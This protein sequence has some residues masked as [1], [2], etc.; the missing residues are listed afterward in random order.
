M[1][2]K[3]TYILITILP[4]LLLVTCQSSKKERQAEF[5]SPNTPSIIYIKNN[6]PEVKHRIPL[7]QIAD[8][9]FY[10][11][12]NHKCP[13]DI[14][15]AWYTNNTIF[16][17]DLDSIFAFNNTGILRYSISAPVSSIDILQNEQKFYIYS[18]K[19]KTISQYDFKGAKEHM[20][21]LKSNKLGGYGSCFLTIND[22][23]FA[24]SR[25]NEGLNPYELLFF[26]KKGKMVKYI[27]NSQPFTPQSHA[28]FYNTAWERMLFRSPQGC[29]Y[30]RPYGDTLF[31][32]SPQI[33]LSPIWIEQKLSKVPLKKRLEYRGMNLT[34][35]INLCRTEQWYNIRYI[36]NSRYIIA[37]YIPGRSNYDIPNYMVYDKKTKKI[38]KTEQTLSKGIAYQNFHFGFFN[39]YDGGLGFSP[40]CQSNDYLLMINAGYA[41]GGAK[42]FP[43]T[44]Y[45]MGR[46]IG[47]ITYKCRSDSCLSIKNKKKLE[48]FLKSFDENKN[49]M[50][51]IVKLKTL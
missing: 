46:K 26:N 18:F 35:F 4:I 32:I 1:T 36:E 34:D 29:F 33:A 31:T 2:M 38:E 7:S 39:D 23:L 3:I 6:Y 10:L 50:V 19:D 13:K 48:K 21:H 28:I 27:T 42:N 37:E 45:N 22:T 9:I 30:Y 40:L 25:L 47:K 49:T 11:K 14:Y 15:Q 5:N 24:I 41:Q 20:I 12:L 16:L 51:T 44:L 8:T 43:K 17:Y